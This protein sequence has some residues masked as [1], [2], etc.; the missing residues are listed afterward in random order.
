VY[1]EFIVWRDNIYESLTYIHPEKEKL[2]IKE[3]I[4]ELVVPNYKINFIQPI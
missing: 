1:S 4:K 3:D 2:K